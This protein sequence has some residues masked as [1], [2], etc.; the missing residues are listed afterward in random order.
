MWIVD[1]IGWV[2]ICGFSFRVFFYFP[3]TAWRQLPRTYPRGTRITHSGHD[4]C[5]S[6]T[7]RSH[8]NELDDDGNVTGQTKNWVV[9]DNS[10]DEEQPPELLTDE[11]VS[12]LNPKL[13]RGMYLT[14]FL[15][16]C[17]ANCLTV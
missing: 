8:C 17:N 14:Y 7:I 10:A 6:G 16:F 2:L 3:F 4:S 5:P 11:E 13:P 9:Y 15:P 1:R 12:K